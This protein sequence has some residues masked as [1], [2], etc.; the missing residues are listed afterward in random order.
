MTLGLKH[1]TIYGI[2]NE[3]SELLLTNPLRDLPPPVELPEGVDPKKLR[4]ERVPH[5]HPPPRRRRRQLVS[6]PLQGVEFQLEQVRPEPVRQN[7]F[8]VRLPPHEQALFEDPRHPVQQVGVLP[9]PVPPPQV[10]EEPVHQATKE[11]LKELVDPQRATASP[12][13]VPW[14]VDDERV[15]EACPVARLQVEL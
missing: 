12:A 7:R 15:E 1:T 11:R 3:A 8:R 2:P 10:S 13:V 4:E 14:G 5:E 9:P 6:L